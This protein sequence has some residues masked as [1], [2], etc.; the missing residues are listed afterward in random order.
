MVMLNDEQIREWNRKKFSL[1]EEMLY[2]KFS[3]NEEAR[4]VLLATDNAEL[5]H[6][7]RGVPKARQVGLERVRTRIREAINSSD[8]EEKVCSSSESSS[9][10]EVKNHDDEEGNDLKRKRPSESK[11]NNNKRR[12]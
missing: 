1:L 5:W 9:E 10:E 11:E 8:D 6:G 7:T 3:Q 12:K 4:K 2:C